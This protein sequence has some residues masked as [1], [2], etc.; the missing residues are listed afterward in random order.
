[1]KI[2]TK[3]RCIECLGCEEGEL[4]PDI[5]V[6]V[7]TVNVVTDTCERVFT[8]IREIKIQPNNGVEYLRLISYEYSNNKFDMDTVRKIEVIL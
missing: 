1:M 6:N 3:Q 8:R 5:D 2:R 7:M 4:C